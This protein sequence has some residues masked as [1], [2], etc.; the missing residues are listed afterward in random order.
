MPTITYREAIR[1][2]LRIELKENPELI[3][4]GEDIGAYGGSYS[5][6]KGFLEEFGAERVVDT[7]IVESSLIGLSIGAAMAGMRPVVELMTINFALKAIDQIINNA[8]KIRFMF[9]GQ[10]SAPLV[11]RAVSG[12]GQLGPTHSQSFENYFAYAPGLMVVM[13]SSPNDAKGLLLTAMRGKDPVLFI[14]HALLYSTQGDVP[15]GKEGIPLGLSDIKRRGKDVSIVAYS[16]MVLLA[17]QAAQQLSKDGIEVEVVDLRCLRPMDLGLAVS[18]LKKTGR[19]LVLSEDWPSCSIAS[20]VAARLQNEAFDYLDAPI[21]LL[22]SKDVPVAYARN[23]EAA[24][25]PNVSDIVGAV[26]A[27]LS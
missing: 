10:F 7:P 1:Q 4:L 26:R 21:G 9:G 2:A 8:A 11:I 12:W 3:L 17:L 16:R 5:V 13:P 18:S 23:L 15:E 20:E 14:E 25:L 22:V 19:A 24:T 6:T 27:L